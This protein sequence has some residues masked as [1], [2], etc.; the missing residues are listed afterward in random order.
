[1]STYIKGYSLSFAS[2]Y[3]LLRIVFHINFA[4]VFLEQMFRVPSA[5]ELT[6]EKFHDFLSLASSPAILKS[7]SPEAADT[8]CTEDVGGEEALQVVG[9]PPA[10]SFSEVHTF[11]NSFKQCNCCVLCVLGFAGKVASQSVSQRYDWL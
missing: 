10:P 2:L 7:G 8:S 5:L 3:P 1:M 11:S 9:T 6:P 4:D